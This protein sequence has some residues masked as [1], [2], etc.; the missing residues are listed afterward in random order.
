MLNVSVTE[1]S[2]SSQNYLKAI[3][4]LQEWDVK[5]VT[6]S[7]L[8]NYAG[9]K[10]PTITEAMKR[11]ASDGLVNY[12]P[13]GAIELTPAGRRAAL[14]MIR[15]HRLLETYLVEMLGYSWDQVHAE[16]E[17]LEHVCSDM[18]IARIDEKLNFPRKDPHGDPI[19]SAD[20]TIE[21]PK[22]SPLST[23]DIG[24]TVV[25]E[26]IS[27]KD[28]ELL[29]HLEQLGVQIGDRL[30]LVAG[31]PFSDAVVANTAAGQITLGAA[32]LSSIWVSRP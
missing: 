6:P 9:V 31:A 10:P 25:V 32:T 3:W 24:R 19:P 11:M 17:Q 1:L 8:A 16:A 26:R 30:D 23:A 4:A 18:L 12:S 2:H 20:G 22:A 15:R 29:V 21:I 13:Y 14:E 5:P 28:P 7:A 27:D